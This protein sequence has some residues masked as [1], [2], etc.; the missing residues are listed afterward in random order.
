ML[1]LCGY[2]HFAASA[3]RCRLSGCC[4]AIR[5]VSSF[6]DEH[7]SA[8]KVNVGGIENIVRQMWMNLLGRFG[9]DPALPGVVWAFS[10]KYSYKDGQVDA[11]EQAL[12]NFI[13]DH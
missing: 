3:R 9:N 10:D 2:G 11:V 12:E 13:C 8:T 1:Y 4:R 7:F 6:V 5:T